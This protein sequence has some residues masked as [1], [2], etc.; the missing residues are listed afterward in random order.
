M[1]LATLGGRYI[2][3]TTITKLDN[4]SDTINYSKSAEPLKRVLTV[5]VDK[6]HR[7]VCCDQLSQENN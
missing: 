1:L 7:H 5:T 3:A 2:R 4:L 6:P